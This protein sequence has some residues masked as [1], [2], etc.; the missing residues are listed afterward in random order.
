VLL[1]SS[2]LRFI[3]LQTSDI[4]KLVYYKAASAS[5]K[6]SAVASQS[7]TPVAN[8]LKP[9]A[10]VNVR[11]AY[12]AS[13]SYVIT[14]DR[15]TRLSENWLT[16]LLPLGEA[17]E[18]YE[19]DILNGAAVVRT[20]QCTS[21]S[22]DYSSTLQ[23]ADF[24]TPQF[25]LAIKVYQISATGGRGAPVAATL[26]R[27]VAYQTSTIT[28]G[29]AMASG[30]VLTVYAGGSSALVTYTTTSGDTLS[31]VATTLAALI[32]ATQYTASAAGQRIS[33]TGPAGIAISVT[34]SRSASPVVLTQ[35]LFAAASPARTATRSRYVL[36]VSNP[37]TG[38]TDPLPA[39][40][41]LSVMLFPEAY[42]S[43]GVTVSYTTPYAMAKSAAFSG[44]VNAVTENAQIGYMGWSISNGSL[45]YG[46]QGEA[47]GPIGKDAHMTGGGILPWAVSVSKQSIGLS[48]STV[49][50]AQAVDFSFIGDNGHGG[51]DAVGGGGVVGKRHIGG[52]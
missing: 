4:G 14:W 16:G 18:S 38:V 47:L 44:L 40:A 23:T 8:V 42:A 37:I 20:I 49:P 21:P 5:Q 31:D 34:A 36:F 51:G 52:G 9:L 50:I 45:E 43:G 48:G 2:G 12:S 22:L 13:G 35:N 19:V 6:L 29:G 24:G 3:K 39:G 33:M 46:A 32:D 41:T 25:S 10:P 15:R 30:V 27:P 26:T 28:L 7:L 17:E 11:N 1:S